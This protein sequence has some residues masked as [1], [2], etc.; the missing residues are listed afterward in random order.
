MI[1]IK[2]RLYEIEKELK[3]LSNQ[4]EAKRK[5]LQDK[6][7]S[8]KEGLFLYT[9]MAIAKEIELISKEIVSICE[10]IKGLLDEKEILERKLSGG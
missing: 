6:A 4:K 8:F 3:E 1:E 7:F 9:E 2:A 10:Q 5:C